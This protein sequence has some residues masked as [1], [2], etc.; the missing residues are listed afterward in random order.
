MQFAP[1]SRISLGSQDQRPD[2]ETAELSSSSVGRHGLLSQAL[3][4]APTA[5]AEPTAQT[6]GDIGRPEA[7]AESQDTRPH[8]NTVVSSPA[9]CTESVLHLVPA[10]HGSGMHCDVLQSQ[11][12]S[13]LRQCKTHIARS[14]LHLQARLVRHWQHHPISLPP[15]SKLRLDRSASAAEPTSSSACGS[16]RYVTPVVLSKVQHYLDTSSPAPTARAT[17]SSS[18]RATAASGTSSPAVQLPPGQTCPA[19]QLPIVAALR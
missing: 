18:V 8:G 4:A 6:V 3:Q 5:Q 11:T 17:S 19:G 7:E 10:F 14:R 9:S 16:G 13:I 1:V 12:I 15:V 2:G